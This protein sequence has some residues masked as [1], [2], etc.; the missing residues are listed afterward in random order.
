[1]RL[2]NILRGMIIPGTV[3]HSREENMSKQLSCEEKALFLIQNLVGK[4]VRVHKL[5]GRLKG[6]NLGSEFDDNVKIKEFIP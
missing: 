1:M 4:I 3:P 5:L 2:E 6:Q